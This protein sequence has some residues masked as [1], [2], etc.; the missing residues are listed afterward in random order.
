MVDISKKSETNRVAIAGG[1]VFVR[2]ATLARIQAGEIAKGDVLAVAQTAGILGAKKTPELIPLCHPLLLSGV[3]VRFE[4]CLSQDDDYAQVHI[5]ATVKS[6]GQTGVEMEAMTAVCV[7]ALTLY[8]MCK[9]IDPSICIGEVRLL[10][11]WGGKSG[12][13]RHPSS[14]KDRPL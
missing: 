13:Y 2:R 8:D 3:E 1:T 12:H 4:P 6:Q 7:A 10:E 14:P 5:T 11:K 9:A